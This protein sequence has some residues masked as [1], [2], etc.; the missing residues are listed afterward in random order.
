MNDLILVKNIK[1]GIDVDFSLEKLYSLHSNIYFKMI[2][3]FISDNNKSLKEELFKECKYSI[4]FAAIQFDFNK[5]TK[6]ST[7]LGNVTKWKCL[8][9]NVKNKRSISNFFQIELS[10]E[11]EPELESLIK[12]DERCRIMID[13][14]IEKVFSIAKD[15]S[16]VRILKILELRYKEGN[17]NKVMPWKLVSKKLGMSIQGC[18]N[19]HN[20]FIKDINKG[21]I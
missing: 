18:I 8:N 6:F 10:Q 13:E 5:N 17:K 15:H 19:I 20:N 4:Y 11:N 3:S 9:L 16:D 1:Q 2:N 12:P 7:Y 14:I 21:K